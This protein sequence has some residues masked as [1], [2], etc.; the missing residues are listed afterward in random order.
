[1]KGAA[2]SKNKAR[3][4]SLRIVVLPSFLFWARA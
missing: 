3:K 4:L 2:H 1:M